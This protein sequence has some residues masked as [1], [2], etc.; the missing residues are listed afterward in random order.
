VVVVVE[1][2]FFV[3]KETASWSISRASKKKE[4]FLSP[5]LVHPGPWP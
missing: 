5:S 1:L 4:A 2:T 3:L